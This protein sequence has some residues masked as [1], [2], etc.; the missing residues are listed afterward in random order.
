MHTLTPKNTLRLLLRSSLSVSFVLTVSCGARDPLGGNEGG[1]E[2]ESSCCPFA[3]SDTRAEPATADPAGAH[4]TPSKVCPASPGLLQLCL[5]IAPADL[6]KLHE[7]PWAR[8]E[9]PADVLIDGVLYPR[10]EIEIH[11]GASRNF[12]KLSYRIKFDDASDTRVDFFGTGPEATKRIVLQASWI[13]PTWSRAKL[14]MDL[15][16]QVGGL[17]PR[18]GHVEVT[19]NDR[20][21]GLYLAIERIDERYLERLE[22]NPNADLFKAETNEA[23]WQV[24][25]DSMR[26]FERQTNEH[27]SD[28]DLGDFFRELAATPARFEDFQTRLSPLL[29]FDDFEIWHGVMTFANNRDTFRKNYYLYHDPS[30]AP[31]TAQALWRIIQWDA[32]ATFGLNWDGEPRRADS[33]EHY[34]AQNAF[35][36]RYFSVPE[37]REAYLHRYADWLKGAFSFDALAPAV[38]ELQDS[39]RPAIDRDLER[40][41]RRVDAHSEFDRLF[42]VLLD[43]QRVLSEQIRGL[44]DGSVVEV[45]QVEPEDEGSSGGSP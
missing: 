17:A 7:D 14:A 27:K 39:L 42:E 35:A 20:Y 1:N 43:R 31:G 36:K 45:A 13:D 5:N 16:R 10:A 29:S 9:V 37:L 26:G 28:D 12:D 4:P 11:G 40:W 2:P 8:V 23:T 22:L 15:T 33:V 25:Q 34:G 19:L 18:M 21:H 38:W 41:G 3:L 44:L 24:R 6:E 32:D 30:A